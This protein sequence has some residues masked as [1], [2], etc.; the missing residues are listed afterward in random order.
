MQYQFPN[1]GLSTFPE[2]HIESQAPGLIP[3]LG[4]ENLSISDPERVLVSSSL[5]H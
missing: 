2:G 3:K 5:K 4:A 1:M